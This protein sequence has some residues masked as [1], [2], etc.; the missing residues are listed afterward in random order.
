MSVTFR[1]ASAADAAT[2]LPMMRALW[3][4]EGIPFDESAI[5]DALGALFADPA[6]GHVW[7]ALADGVPAGYAMGTWA[8]STEQGGRFLLLDEILVATAFQGR[9]I[10]TKLLAFLEELVRESGAGAIRLEVAHENVRAREL[11]LSCG[12]TDPGR[13][14]LAKRLGPAPP[15]RRLRPERVEA[16]VLVKADPD[17]VWRAIAT[18]PG[19]DGWFTA[20][21]VLDATPGG[22]LVFRWERWGPDAFTGTYEGTVLEADSPRRFSFRWPVDA[23]TYDTTVAIDLEARVDGTLV[24]LVEHGFEEGAAGLREM[25]NRSAGWG[26]ALALM[27]LFVEHGV[28]A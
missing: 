22:R 2:F 27:K 8:F 20:G 13:D 23:K 10:G 1:T 24:R 26:E 21:T 28:R 19:L 18:A 5:R 12:Y 16:K 4:H 17:R 11:Y 25:L 9:G 14:F 6:L 3:E 15:G 7:L